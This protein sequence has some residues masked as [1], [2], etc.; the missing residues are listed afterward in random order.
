MLLLIAASRTCDVHGI[1][2]SVS[3]PFSVFTLELHFYFNRVKIYV[4]SCLITT[5]P[6]R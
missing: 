1:A 5:R 4:V 2:H 3:I 6:D